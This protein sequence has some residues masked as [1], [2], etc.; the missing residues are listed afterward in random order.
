MFSFVFV[1]SHLLALIFFVRLFLPKRY[2]CLNPYVVGIDNLLM[3]FLSF[4]RVAFP[5]DD[6]ILCLFLMIG[7]LSTRAVL[8][9]QVDGGVVRLGAVALFTF[10]P[11]SF[12]QWLEVE[13]F[14][15]VLFLVTLWSAY[16]VLRIWCCRQ[17]FQG[18]SG[19]LLVMAC[20]PFS[21]FRLA[22]QWGILCV[23]WTS[24]LLLLYQNASD[25]T[26]PL[27]EASDVVAYF[28]QLHIVNIFDLRQFPHFIRIIFLSAVGFLNVFNELYT[29]L[30]AFFSLHLL[31]RLLRMRS[32]QYFLEGALRLLCGRLPAITFFS[33]DVS[34]LV[35]MIMF[36]VVDV[37]LNGVLCMSL[38]G[39]AHVV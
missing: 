10:H 26:Y 22:V 6:R 11:S 20:S 9:T 2:V 27:G 24:L 28:Q 30:C 19:G 36:S 38:L 35:A 3:R 17:V 14:Q 37:I 5:F 29:I 12:I 15:F 7:S 1:M 34:P 25:I 4:L 8:L 18:F 39:V 21:R 13:V 32:I 31:A 23:L 16:V 33:V